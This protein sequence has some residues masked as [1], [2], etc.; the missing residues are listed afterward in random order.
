MDKKFTRN[1]I[2]NLK[3]IVNC[4]IIKILGW[5]NFKSRLSL[6]SK[7]MILTLA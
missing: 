7:I 1:K 4:L 5:D 6:H 2:R 3:Q